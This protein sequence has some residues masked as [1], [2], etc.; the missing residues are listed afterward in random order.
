M[1]LFTHFTQSFSSP[2]QLFKVNKMPQTREKRDLNE[3][4]RRVNNPTPAEIRASVLAMQ[5]D[6]D[7]MFAA[8]DTENALKEQAQTQS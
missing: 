8:I 3:L 7:E 4:L 1:T 6:D 2:N 5:A